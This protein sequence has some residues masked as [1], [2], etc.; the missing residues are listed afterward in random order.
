MPCGGGG[1]RLAAL[2]VVLAGLLAGP[3]AAGAHT[4]LV[5]TEASDHAVALTFSKPASPRL[6]RIDV[7]AA[8]GGDLD[9]GEP[10]NAPGDP[11]TVTLPLRGELRNGRYFVTWSTA[12]DDAHVVS[13]VFDFSVS[14]RRPRER[15]ATGPRRLRGVPPRR[16]AARCR[17]RGSRRTPR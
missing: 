4:K 5:R 13:G 1:L 16:S 9:P 15:A 10:R 8:T 3:G 7:L 11:K 6:T 17:W 2:A 12:N 14:P